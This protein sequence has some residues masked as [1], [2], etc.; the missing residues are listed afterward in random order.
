MVQILTLSNCFRLFPQWESKLLEDCLIDSPIRV[1]VIREVSAGT[2]RDPGM[3][4]ICGRTEPEEGVMAD[5]GCHPCLSG[6]SGRKNSL[7]SHPTFCQ[8][9]WS[10]VMN[11]NSNKYNSSHLLRASHMSVSV[12]DTTCITSFLPQNNPRERALFSCPL[13]RCR[14]PEQLNDLPVVTELTSGGVMTL[15]QTVRGLHCAV[16]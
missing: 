13:Y 14:K 1:G 2:G 16:L 11:S 8:P 7:S 15:S 3:S 4:R 12:L 6:P 9:T 5:R 10:P